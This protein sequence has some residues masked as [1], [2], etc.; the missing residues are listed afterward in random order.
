ML[1][2]Q[3]QFSF[4]D[5]SRIDGAIRMVNLSQ[6]VLEKDGWTY[7]GMMRLRALLETISA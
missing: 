1:R 3:Q 7:H 4:F 5:P 2:Y 6:I